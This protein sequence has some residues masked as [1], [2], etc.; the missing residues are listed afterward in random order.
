[1]CSFG[2]RDIMC[3]FGS[4]DN[5]CPFGSLHVIFFLNVFSSD[6]EHI[7]CAKKRQTLFYD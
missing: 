6:N 5:M 7:A 2:S 3:S 1:M 4:R